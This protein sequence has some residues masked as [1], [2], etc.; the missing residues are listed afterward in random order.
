MVMEDL[1]QQLRVPIKVPEEEEE[2]EQITCLPKRPSGDPIILAIEKN[3]FSTNCMC[4][5]N[6][7]VLLGIGLMV[8]ST[9]IHVIDLKDMC[10]I[11]KA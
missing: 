11:V 4:V 7:I 6:L 5:F 9:L 2:E 1:K 10:R 8:H 3:S